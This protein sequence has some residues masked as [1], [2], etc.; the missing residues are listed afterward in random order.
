VIARTLAYEL[1]GEA[2]IDFA[3]EGLRTTLIM[4]FTPQLGD[5]M[6]SQGESHDDAHHAP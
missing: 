5:M 1:E 2:T 3:A 4:P 6:A